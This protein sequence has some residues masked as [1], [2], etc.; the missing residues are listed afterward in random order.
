MRGQ[1]IVA[2]VITSLVGF[3][4]AFPIVL[5]GLRAVGATQADAAS[6]LLAVTVL[7]GAAGIGLSLRQRMPL[8]IAW[9]TP[10]AALLIATGTVGGGYPAA[11][12][13]FLVCGALLALCGLSARLERAIRAIPGPI[14]AAVLAGVLL[15]IC[16]KPAQG[17]VAHPDLG[18]PV[19]VVWLVLLRVARRW[20]VVGMLAT[21]LVVI[22]IDHPGG[23]DAGGL[24]PQFVF[25]A[26]T[27]HLGTLLGLGLPLFVVT[28]ASQNIPGMAVLSTYG[29]RPPLRPV[30]L[31]TGGLTVV[32]APFGVIGINLAA[33]TAALAAGPEAGPDPARRWPA[34]VASG[35]TYLVLGLLAG[36]AASLVAAAPDGVIETAVG[37]ALF[38]P[39]AN[40]IGVATR[41]EA[42][43]EAA[44]VT[45]VV[46]ASGITVAGISAPFWGLVAGLGFLA[47][48]RRQPS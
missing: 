6:G 29:F 10:G 44:V 26:P 33:I 23:L 20:A 16:L 22:L 45:L 41:D 5:A 46:A 36:G 17:V 2:G 11:I 7:M 34:G 35:A 27:L 40:A 42:H 12:G 14:A 25:T 13:A 32:G 15:P 37:L 21:T 8:S 18:G 28:M 3:L 1:A 47:V 9:T 31:T 4:G 48:Q 30:L 43:R 39:L 19:V 38:A 24:T